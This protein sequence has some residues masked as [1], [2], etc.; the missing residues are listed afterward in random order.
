[1]RAHSPVRGV[2]CVLSPCCGC[3]LRM[4]EKRSLLAHPLLFPSIPPPSPTA[5]TQ[6]LVSPHPLLSPAARRTASPTPS[7]A[8]SSPVS[9]SPA[10][11]ASA[12]ATRTLSPLLSQLQSARRRPATTPVASLS[13]IPTP[14]GPLPHQQVA[15]GAA[16]SSAVSTGQ[17][18]RGKRGTGSDGEGARAGSK[19]DDSPATAVAGSGATGTRRVLPRG[20]SSDTADAPPMVLPMARA[21]EAVR[22]LAAQGD[23]ETAESAAVQAGRMQAQESGEASDAAVGQ[24]PEV[25][26]TRDKAIRWLL[27]RES[28]DGPCAY[29]R[30]T[31]GLLLPP[32]SPRRL[33]AFRQSM[34]APRP[35]DGPPK[36]QRWGAGS[37]RN[38]RV[39]P[40]H[41]LTPSP[42]LPPFRHPG[43]FLLITLCLLPI[44]C[45]V[46][47]SLLRNACPYRSGRVGASQSHAWPCTNE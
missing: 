3:L 6:G 15:R 11:S 12:A 24:Q 25:G 45:S 1:M 39:S 10:A 9:R 47:S 34:T 14:S 28:L 30:E 7:S 43:S 5:R 38:L 35:R 16:A 22:A 27:P 19:S 20:E 17:P 18:R 40:S 13:Q 32:H 21:L 8:T 4:P 36:Q 41:P 31:N 44:S 37:D 26:W 42:S 23:G 33:L 29:A 46:C 2:V